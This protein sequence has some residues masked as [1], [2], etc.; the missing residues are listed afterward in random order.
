VAAGGAAT[1]N[2]RLVADQLAAAVGE[3]RRAFD[4][5]CPLLLVAACGEPSD[6]PALWK[7]AA[8]DRDAGGTGRIAARDG[9]FQIGCEETGASMG[10]VGNGAANAPEQASGADEAME[11]AAFVDQL[12]A[13][14]RKHP[15]RLC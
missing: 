7:H 13:R 5:A 2:R 3:N 15:D 1:A 8:K 11:L 4:K 6:A 10:V 14:P 9:G 12:R